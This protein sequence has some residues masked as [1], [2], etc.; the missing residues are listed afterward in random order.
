VREHKAG[1]FLP[2][3][4]RSSAVQNSRILVKKSRCGR[5]ET[6]HKTR[7]AVPNI[8]GVIELL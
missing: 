7:V 1:R 5:A 6:A 2:E 4:S 3:A 8:V